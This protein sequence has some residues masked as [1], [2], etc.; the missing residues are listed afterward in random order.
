MLVEQRSEKDTQVKSKQARVWATGNHSVWDISSTLV[1]LGVTHTVDPVE[2]HRQPMKY[3]PGKPQPIAVHVSPHATSIRSGAV[4]FISASVA[5]LADTNFLP[6]PCAEL[7]VALK[8]MLRSN[9]G[10]IPA[11]RTRSAGDYVDVLATPSILNH[12]QTEVYRIQPYS[13]RKEVQALVIKFF[14]SEVSIRDTNKVLEKS[15]KTERLKPIFKQALPLREAVAMM[16]CSP[17]EAVAKAT[18]FSTFEL[19]YL[20][21]A[22]LRSKD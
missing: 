11:I 13:L 2:K 19:L 20:T 5:E 9:G 10:V 3:G 7:D 14:N 16:K 12:I 15:I 6:F 17:V 22:K 1:R 8:K 21:K 4:N 18:G